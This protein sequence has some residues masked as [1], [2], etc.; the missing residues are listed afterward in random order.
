VFKDT[1]LISGVMCAIVIWGS[2]D[3]LHNF[4]WILYKC[5]RELHW[6]GGLPVLMLTIGCRGICATLNNEVL[7]LLFFSS[8]ITLQNIAD[9]FS[10]TPL[11]VKSRASVVWNH[12]IA[13]TQWV[14]HRAPNVVL[15][16]G[17][18]IPDIARISIDV[19]AL[20]TFR[21]GHRIADRTPG[22]VHNPNAL[23]GATERVLIEEITSAFVQGAVHSNNITPGEEVA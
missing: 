13:T 5:L 1:V 8:K 10:V 3:I 14:L 7:G 21:N 16:C 15:G 11:S 19:A 23:L 2:D 22:G 4:D 20:E 6:F 18:M 9:T 17:L 12:A